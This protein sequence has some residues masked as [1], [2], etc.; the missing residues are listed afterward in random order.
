[1]SARKR[2]L[3][4]CQ[5]GAL[6]LAVSLGCS[7]DDSPT[8]PEEEIPDFP[9]STESFTG[10]FGMDETSEH[11]FTLTNPGDVDME[12]T[13][14]EPVSTLTVGLGIGS[15][16]ESQET[17]CSIFASDNRVNVGSTLFSGNLAAGDYCVAIGDVGNV[18]PDATVTYTVDVT[19][20]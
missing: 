15:W 16:D 8:Q 10:T 14:L 7:E 17:P 18:F 6:A 11:P 12:I 19:H 1:M 2:F 20:P 9:R 13:S 5:I 4:F 3:M